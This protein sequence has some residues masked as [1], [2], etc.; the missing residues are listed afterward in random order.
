VL[1]CSI[2]RE[3]DAT[4]AFLHITS[5]SRLLQLCAAHHNCSHWTRYWAWSAR[6]SC[7][8]PSSAHKKALPISAIYPDSL[9]SRQTVNSEKWSCCKTT[10]Q[11]YS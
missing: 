2:H 3:I 5:T 11:S 1:G 10:T 6:V 7:V 4:V 8:M 9:K